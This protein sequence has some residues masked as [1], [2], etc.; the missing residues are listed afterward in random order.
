MVIFY[1]MKVPFTYSTTYL[2][3]LDNYNLSLRFS[4]ALFIKYNNACNSTQLFIPLIT[5][6]LKEK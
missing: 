6:I 1:N 3:S 4:E 5:H 2:E